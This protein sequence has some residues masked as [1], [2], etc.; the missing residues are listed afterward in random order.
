MSSDIVMEAPT[1]RVKR[2]VF[3]SKRA[4]AN[5]SGV[6]NFDGSSLSLPSTQG[7]RV[8]SADSN[9]DLDVLEVTVHEV[10]CAVIQLL[11]C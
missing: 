7:S 3:R 11:F 1:N 4:P 6:S 8:V 2:F 5:R 10:S 9:N